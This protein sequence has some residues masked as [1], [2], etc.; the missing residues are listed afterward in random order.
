MNLLTYRTVSSASAPPSL[1][2]RSDAISADAD[3]RSPTNPRS[4]LPESIFGGDSHKH[5][6]HYC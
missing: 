4:S 1:A 3:P 5:E 6:I 2:R